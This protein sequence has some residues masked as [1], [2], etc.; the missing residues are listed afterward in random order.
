MAEMSNAERKVARALLARYPSSALT[1]IAELAAESGVSAPTVLRFA[2]RLG[3]AGFLD[4]QRALVDELNDQ[5]SPLRQYEAKRPATSD[6]S[7]LARTRDSFSSLLAVTYEELPES[8]FLAVAGILADRSKRIV[9]AGGRF[10]KFLGDYLASHLQLLRAGVETMPQD[11]IARRS[12]VLA[13]NAGTVLVVF[14]YRRYTEDTRTLAAE[15]R[16][17][18]SIVCLMTDNWLSPISEFAKHV[19]PAHVDSASPFDSII[20]ATA[21]TESLIAAVTDALG[22]AGMD[23]VARFEEQHGLPGGEPREN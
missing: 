9:V 13:A 12:T 19:I 18:G 4:L 2:G 16:S 8:E 23:R 22:H 5:G 17:R 10:S 21:V 3:Y 20:S 11:E 15:M 7:V 1:T 14:D 6:D